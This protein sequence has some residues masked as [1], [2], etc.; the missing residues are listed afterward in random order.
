MEERSGYNADTGEWN[1]SLTGEYV[2]SSVNTREA[3]PDVM[4]PYTW[5]AIRHGFT[6]MILL[7]GYLPVGNI[8][9]RV[10]NN[11]TVGATAFRALG[12][13]NA[14]DA[15]SKELYGIDPGKIDEWDFPLIPVGIWERIGLIRNALRI[16]TNVRSGLKAIDSFLHT[17]PDWCL[18]QRHQLAGMRRWELIS[19]SE[20]VYLPYMIKVFWGM[21]SPAIALS[22]VVSKL[23][24][25]LLAIVGPQESVALLS[26]VSSE[27]EIL[28]S[29]GVVV[30]LDALRRGR[31][32]QE[33]YLRD[34]GHRGPHEVELS[35][36]RPGEDP[37]EHTANGLESLACLAADSNGI[38][39][40][41]SHPSRK[42]SAIRIERVEFPAETRRQG[43]HNPSRLSSYLA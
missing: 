18:A 4:T 38:V 39:H 11:A 14:F 25:D 43:Q 36:P 37:C 24:A 35:I 23:R 42:K 22:N 1:D 15:S 16:M 33:D 6:Q 21:V 5:S 7:P 28:A 29:L 32:S 12:A 19:W 10:Y 41:L 27:Q 31:I 17:N 13:G 9:G 26:N 20:Q 2:W 3:S 34:Y 8:C 40:S 30:G